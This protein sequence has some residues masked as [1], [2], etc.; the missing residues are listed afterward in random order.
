[1]QGARKA[2]IL[3]HETAISDVFVSYQRRPRRNALR[4]GRAAAWRRQLRLM[5]A[6]HRGVKDARLK[7]IAHHISNPQRRA[8]PANVGTH[9]PMASHYRR[10]FMSSKRVFRVLLLSAI[11]GLA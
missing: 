10:E 1:M 2:K 9:F 6:V 4:G 3:Y 11:A 8:L 5:T 7:S